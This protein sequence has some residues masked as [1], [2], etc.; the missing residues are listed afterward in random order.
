MTAIYV[1]IALV[2]GAALAVQ[3]G[4][5]NGLRARLGHPIL[6][7]LVSFLVGTA[8][9]LV[10]VAI[11]RPAVPGPSELRRGPWW[12]WLGGVVG[13]VYV[14]CSAEFARRLGAAGWVSLIIAGQTLGSLALDHFGLVGFAPHPISAAR[15]LG[16]ALLLVGVALVLRT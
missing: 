12:I 3:V 9:L 5:N 16:A 4:L 11:L 13:A 14:G 10:N 6:A 1:V 8:L 7:A 15:L 2:S